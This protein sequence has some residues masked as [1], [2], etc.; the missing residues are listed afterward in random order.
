M[1]ITTY[2]H[3]L[4]GEK[5]TIV[6]SK[7]KCNLGIRGIIVDETKMA[8]KVKQKDK[9]K[10]LLKNNVVIRL[11]KNGVII[12]GQELAKRPEERIKG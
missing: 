12:S 7:N 3:E 1:S 2:P 8:I 11:E 6:S 9:T 10:T 4:I 5:I